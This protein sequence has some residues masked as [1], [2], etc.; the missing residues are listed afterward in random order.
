M[1]GVRTDD[2]DHPVVPPADKSS[3]GR[4][5]SPGREKARAI[6]SGGGL[7][8]IFPEREARA[9]GGQRKSDCL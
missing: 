4:A 2:V 7:H 8:L 9:G 3:E 5:V 1:W 6:R